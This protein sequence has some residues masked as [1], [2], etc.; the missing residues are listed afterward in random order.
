MSDFHF[1]AAHWRT[2]EDGM[3]ATLIRTVLAASAT[4]FFSVAAHGAII[5]VDL[6]NGGATNQSPASTDVVGPYAS[7]GWNNNV[8]ITNP[9]NSGSPLTLTDSNSVSGG[10]FAFNV[11]GAMDNG[12][13]VYNPSYGGTG[14]AN[15]ALTPN[16]QLYNGAAAAAGGG[17]GQEFTVSNIP[18]SQFSAYVLVQ[19]LPGGT[20]VNGYGDVQIFSGSTPTPGTTYWFTYENASSNAPT[21]TPSSPYVQA[22]GTTQDTSTPN[23]NYVLYTGLAGGAGSEY[24]FDL[25]SP[26]VAYNNGA[27]VT[28]VEIVDTSSIPE[29]TTL[30]LLGVGSLGLLSRRRRA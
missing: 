23:A 29:P 11:G 6:N 22:T 30:T 5:G 14:A 18:Y 21:P 7:A 4:A 19:A 25:S 20:D 8:D 28:G 27:F 12:G 26:G 2:T 1:R 24:T 10:T 3:K 17:Y 15:G 9:P 16:Q 13:S